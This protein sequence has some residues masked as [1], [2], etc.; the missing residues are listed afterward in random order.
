MK[1]LLKYVQGLGVG[2]VYAMFEY[3]TAQT[4]AGTGTDAMI[5]GLILAAVVRVMGLLIAKVG[6]KA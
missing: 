5:H 6:P 1:E 2:A 3:F 4:A